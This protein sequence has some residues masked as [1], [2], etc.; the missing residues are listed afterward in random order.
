MSLLF[1]C[2]EAAALLSDYQD[3]IL[4]LASLLKLKVHL[5]SCPACRALL[6]SLRALPEL[7]G[8]SP[9]I[10]AGFEALAQAALQGALARLAQPG[11]ARPWPASPVPEQAQALLEAGADLPLRILACTHATLA[12]SRDRL[13]SPFH[14][15]P[16]TLDQLPPESQWQWETDPDGLRRAELLADPTGGQR[17][18]LVHAPAGARL[19]A[20]RHLGSESI[21]VLAGAMED[22]GLTWEAGTWIHH[23]RGSSHGPRIPE[24]GCWF[25]VR[26]E[27]SVRFQGPAGWLRNSHAAS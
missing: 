18:F 6:A 24:A 17:L 4:P 1:T 12:S 21:L 10:E 7:I 11:T 13:S 3:G 9:V 15:P 23:G 20:H 25:L 8:R 26:E 16:D 19:A 2:E 14:L 27:G 5:Y 22:R